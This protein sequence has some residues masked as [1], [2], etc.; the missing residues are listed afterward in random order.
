M[1]FDEGTQTQAAAA[2]G[3]LEMHEL[4]VD[5]SVHDEPAVALPYFADE[6]EYDVFEQIV[7]ALITDGPPVKN[8]YHVGGP[9]PGLP[10]R[11]VQEEP[12][13]TQGLDG[14]YRTMQ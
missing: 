2:P 8:A 4:I 1:T 10:D 5:R 6:P 13:Y 12:E 9:L 3:K 14:P 7:A 11:A